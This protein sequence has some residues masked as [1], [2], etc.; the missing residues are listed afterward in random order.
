MNNDIKVIVID[1]LMPENT[2]LMVILR[3]TYQNENVLMFQES[4]EGLDYVISHLSD[5][6]IV[7]LDLGFGNGQMQGIDVFE[8]ITDK[9]ELVHVIVLTS[10]ELGQISKTDL[11]KMINND[12]MALVDRTEGYKKVLEYVAK[13]AHQLETRVDSVIERWI[14]RH[15]DEEREQPYMATRS[16][17]RYS[18][19]DVLQEI[20]HQTE[21]GKEMEKKILYLTIDLLTR[22][23]E[24]IDD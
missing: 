4:K 19:N 20:R 24:A 16:G 13:A 7:I 10:Q 18:L 2:P 5:K 17:K 1:D 11:Q 21:F 12:A 9:T 14:T 6:M 8:K 23:K 22:E 3:E 15:S